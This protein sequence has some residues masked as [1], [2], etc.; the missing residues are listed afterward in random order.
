MKQTVT[1]T[2]IAALIPLG[3]PPA[4]AQTDPV[5]TLDGGSAQAGQ[6]PW[7]RQTPQTPQDQ[8]AQQD[9]QAA[10]NQQATQARQGQQAPGAADSPAGGAGA[11]PIQM[12]N[13]SR[14]QNDKEPAPHEALSFDELKKRV[15]RYGRIIGEIPLDTPDLFA[16]MVDRNGSQ[17]E[18]YIT[19]DGSA[20]FAGVLLNG[21]PQN[22]AASDASPGPGEPS[23]PSRTASSPTASSPDV[24]SPNASL[25]DASSPTA[26]A[27]TDS[28]SAE[29]SSTASAP[30]AASRG[31][32]SG[33]TTGD[34]K[35]IATSRAKGNPN[36]RFAMDG[37]FEGTPPPVIQY[38]DK[39]AGFREGKG[40][41]GDTVYIFFDPRCPYCRA[42]YNGTRTHVRQ[43]A[44]IKWIPVALLGRREP[45]PDGKYLDQKGMRLSATILQNSDPAFLERVLGRK[46]P[47][48]T[49]PAGATVNNLLDNEKMM[50]LLFQAS[51]DSGDAGVPA[52]L[53]LDHRTGIARLTTGLSEQ[54]IREDILGKP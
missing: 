23:S 2:L 25:P 16:W 5:Q 22:N 8:Q 42:A 41:P 1:R 4:M 11:A 32:A 43:G 9:Q 44:T 50:T 10:Q 20:I 13:A 45:T 24:S 26:S 3:A 12:L 19:S 53:Y 15:S 7:T 21:G 49:A 40:A 37:H 54:V 35:P 29:P 47:I 51:P 6:A 52:A 36:A 48:E 46:E 28:P 39:L 30:A 18:V 34:S 31:A 14:I 27:P 38:V 33:D 17:I